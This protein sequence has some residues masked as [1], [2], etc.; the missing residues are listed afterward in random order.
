[1]PFRLTSRLHRTPKSAPSAPHRIVRALRHHS[2]RASVLAERARQPPAAARWPARMAA[3]VPVAD[4]RPCRG[5]AH[6]AA[7]AAAEAIA[8]AARAVAAS[9]K[10]RAAPDQPAA[11]SRGE[12]RLVRVRRALNA[13]P[14]R[15]IS[16]RCAAHR[17]HAGRRRGPHRRAARAAFPE[18]QPTIKNPGL[19]RGFCLLSRTCVRRLARPARRPPLRRARAPCRRLPTRIPALRGRSGRKRRSSRRSGAAGRA[20][21]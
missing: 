18:A 14:A 6:R 17:T 5:A 7:L 3:R 19:N 21:G 11:P 20:S 8:A 9:R 2:A 1:M 15:G 13:R 16:P 10:R 4:E 12:H